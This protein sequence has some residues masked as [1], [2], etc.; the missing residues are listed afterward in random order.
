MLTLH[1]TLV[2]QW[3]GLCFHCQGL[4]SIPGRR[5]KIPQATWHS[6][7]IKINLKIKIF[8]GET[9]LLELY[10]LSFGFLNYD[11]RGKQSYNY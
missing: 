5:T 10:I 7:K 1:L 9:I 11:C 6:Q 2:V 3:L 4:G 8:L